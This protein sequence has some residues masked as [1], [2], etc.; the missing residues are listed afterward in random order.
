MNDTISRQADFV[1]GS[2]SG[3]RQERRIEEGE[4]WELM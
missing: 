2:C 4:G 1:S 3:W